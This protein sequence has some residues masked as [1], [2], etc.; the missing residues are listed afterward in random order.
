MDSDDAALREQLRVFGLSDN[1]INTYFALLELGE[2]TTSAVADEAGVTQRSV[3]NI[4]ERLEGRGLVRVN[5][6]VSPTTIR[7]LPPREAMA[8]I[9]ERIDAMT[10]ALEERFTE[11]RPRT[12]EIEMAKSR[13]KALKNLREDIESAESEVLV[14]VPADVVPEIEDELR[15]ARERG[16]LVLLLVGEVENIDAAAERYAG[17]AT[18][19]RCWGDEMAFAYA[20]DDERAMIGSPEVFDG[21]YFEEGVVWVSEWGLTG[22]VIATFLGA[23]WPFPWEVH[24]ADPVELPATFEWFRTATFTAVRH[25]RMGTDLRAAVETE[26][27]ERVVGR[28]NDVRQAL[29]DPATNQFTLENGFVLDTDEGTVSVGASG[30]YLEDYRGTSV[31]L[32]PVED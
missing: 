27:G 17:L 24:V 1:E 5:D 19:V 8:D 14:S 10:P 18:V 25:R 11:T 16:A 9:S 29:V 21:A 31:R 15:A 7:A 28:V 2:A 13:R 6:H 32:R 4:V 26:S 22:A 23:Y 30:G 12:S 20:V 3:Y